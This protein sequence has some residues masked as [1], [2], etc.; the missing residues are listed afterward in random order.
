MRLP[1]MPLRTVTEETPP[2]VW[3]YHC[4][5][6]TGSLGCQGTGEQVTRALGLVS[7]PESLV[8]KLPTWG[9]FIHVV[10]WCG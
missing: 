1:S 9:M 3:L 5:T 2:L 10:L 4:T 7:E 8:P 6:V